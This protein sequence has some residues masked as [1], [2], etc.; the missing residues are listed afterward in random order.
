MHTGG[1][2]TLGTDA[3]TQQKEQRSEQHNVGKNNI[4]GKYRRKKSQQRKPGINLQMK[5]KGTQG[6]QISF[7][8]VL[9]SRI[10]D[11]LY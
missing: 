11:C 2:Q 8:R 3:I 4:K 9:E 6:L 10:F 1:I 5:Q 7:T